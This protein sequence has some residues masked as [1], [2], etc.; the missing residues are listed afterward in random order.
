MGTQPKKTP[1]LCASAQTDTAS[2]EQVCSTKHL[3]DVS[4]PAFADVQDT[5]VNL[6]FPP[7]S[8]V[9]SE[10]ES[11]VNGEHI[12]L[13]CPPGLQRRSITLALCEVLQSLVLCTCSNLR[14][15]SMAV[16]SSSSQC[17][18]SLPCKTLKP[19]GEFLP[20]P[21]AEN[22]LQHL[23]EAST[24]AAIQRCG[25]SVSCWHF[26]QGLLQA[27]Q[28]QNQNEFCS[29]GAVCSCL[30][31]GRSRGELGSGR[32]RH[33]RGLGA[34]SAALREGEGLKVSPATGSPLLGAD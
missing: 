9:F 1:C 16:D 22:F 14:S 24:S 30:E 11:G 19:A 23:H 20:C 34:A 33:G 15:C 18:P 6:F 12:S 8:P 21:A 4:S 2:S 27:S 32:W 26:P 7:V 28:K 13:G 25:V 3:Q 5:R 10:H 29:P 17:K 31:T